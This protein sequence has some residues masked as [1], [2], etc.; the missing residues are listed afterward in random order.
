MKR[1]TA[2]LLA[3]LMLTAILGSCKG[4]GTPMVTPPNETEAPSAPTTPE[5]EDTTDYELLVS[6]PFA[7]LAENPAE[8]FAFFEENGEITVTGYLGETTRVRIPEKINQKTVTALA[9]GAF[10]AHAEITTLYIPDTVTRFGKNVLLGC[11]GIYALRTPLPI[12]EGQAYLGYLYG[13]LSYETNNTADLRTLAYLELGGTRAELPTYALYD[14]NDIVCIKLPSTMTVLAEY[15][16]YRCES[17][18]YIN[19]EHLTKVGAH[20]MHGCKEMTDLSFGNSLQEVGLGALEECSAMRNLTLPFVGKSRTELT[21]LSHLFGAKAPTLARSCYPASL[22]TVQLLEG[23]AVIGDHA[24]FDCTTLRSVVIPNSVTSVGV[25]AFEGC[26]RIEEI[27]FSDALLTVREHAFSDCTLLKT[28]NLGTGLTSLGINAF[29]NCDAL[30]EITLN[31]PTLEALPSSCFVG[32][33]ALKAVTL[34]GVRRISESAF[35]GCF[36][37]ETVSLGDV[38]TVEENAFDGCEKLQTVTAKGSVSFAK[39]NDIA[40]SLWKENKK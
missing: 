36:A 35:R 26:A 18:K 10:R 20:A 6:A 30:T 17:L 38:T 4:K 31:A 40:K 21:Y 33:D 15:S 7:E 11:K 19:A 16:L 3:V 14:C 8:D 29:L 32:C 22:R 25:R 24:F 23:C 34:W 2:T 37:L 13:A 27:T 1:I 9:D 39:G 5:T 12:E 28:V